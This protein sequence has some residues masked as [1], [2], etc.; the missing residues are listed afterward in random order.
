MIAVSRCPLAGCS[1]MGIEVNQLTQKDQA[2]IARLS[3]DAGVAPEAMALEIL[4]AYLRLSNDARAAIPQG[5]INDLG[6]RAAR[7][8]GA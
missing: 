3:R 6:V 2:A 4:G 1:L 7:Q 8:V 5:A